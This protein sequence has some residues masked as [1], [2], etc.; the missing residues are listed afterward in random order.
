MIYVGLLYAGSGRVQS[1]PATIFYISSISAESSAE[2][3]I[4]RSFLDD[5][6]SCII[7]LQLFDVLRYS[8]LCTTKLDKSFQQRPCVNTFPI[9]VMT[10]QSLSR[11]AHWLG[12]RRRL[13]SQHLV[14]ALGKVQADGT[15]KVHKAHCPR[16]Y[17]LPWMEEA[18]IH[19]PSP[20]HYQAPQPARE[21]IS[22]LFIQSLSSKSI[23]FFTWIFSPPSSSPVPIPQQSPNSHPPSAP[24]SDGPGPASIH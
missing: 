24:P 5:L 9:R 23:A 19:Y 10:I 22:S 6:S 2:P 21:P 14:I 15:I 13:M 17:A 11:V 4:P 1:L 18:A 3:Q 12:R 7:I 8:D 16:W 20:S